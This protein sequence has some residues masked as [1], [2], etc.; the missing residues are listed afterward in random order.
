MFSERGD[1]KLKRDML[2][3]VLKIQQKEFGL[4][5]LFLTWTLKGLAHAA[6]QLGNLD[7]KFSL[8]KRAYD[9]EEEELGTDHEQTRVTSY[10]LQQV[11]QQL[12][13]LEDPDGSKELIGLF[14]RQV[15]LNKKI[16]RYTKKDGELAP[17]A[18]SNP[19]GSDVEL[20]KEFLMNAYGG[21]SSEFTSEAGIRVPFYF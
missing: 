13:R 2:Q 17:V 7:K 10:F 14:G 18:T 11:G 5:S 19:S 15:P 9:L 3:K 6:G 1:Y 12:R 8:L 20:P 21:G 16:N 4:D